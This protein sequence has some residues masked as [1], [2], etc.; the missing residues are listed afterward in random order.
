MNTCV[1]REIFWKPRRF[2]KQGDF[3]NPDTG[4]HFKFYFKCPI[5]GEEIFGN[6]YQSIERAVW[7]HGW[8]HYSRRRIR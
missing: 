3:V 1:S 6:D 8:Y 2:I 7:T 5:C 4:R